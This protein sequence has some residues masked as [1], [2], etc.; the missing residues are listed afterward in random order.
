MSMRSASLALAT[1]MSVAI[2][3]SLGAAAQSGNAPNALQGFS[4]NR[5]EPVKIEAASLELRDREK[6]ATFAGNVQLMQGDT[7]LRCTTLVVFYDQEGA[8]AKNAPKTASFGG[9]GQQQIRRLEA[10]GG[11][12]VTQ[13]DQTATSDTG[14]FDMRAN[15][16]TLLGN[17]VVTQG[18]NVLRGERLVVDLTTGVSRVE[19]AQ[20]GSGRVQGLLFPGA[21]R[22]PGKPEPPKND[23][24]KN[25]PNRAEVKKGDAKGGK[26]DANQGGSRP[27]SRPLK[28]N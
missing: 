14:I 6:I 8:A 26:D 22:D 25:D 21:A 11:V 15:T 17:V 23:G 9:G 3:G 18:Q 4:Q 16:A 13:K 27:G 7:T 20:E 19:S 12:V 10:R 5:S 28:L 24:R 2:G 1:S